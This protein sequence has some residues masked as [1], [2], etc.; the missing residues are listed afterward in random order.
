MTK[1]ENDDLK[2]ME[3]SGCKV[4][5]MANP[6]RF[7]TRLDETNYALEDSGAWSKGLV[8]EIKNTR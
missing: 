5:Q 1:A 6:E 8:D 2:A 7:M 3:D 4:L